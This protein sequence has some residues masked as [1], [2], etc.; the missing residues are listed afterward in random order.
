MD[1]H[2]LVVKQEPISP[3][4]GSYINLKVA[5]NL[6]ELDPFFRVKRDDPLQQ[7]FIK[8]SHRANVD[9][10]TIR[11]LYDG[12]R[13]DRNRTPNQMGMEDGDCIDAMTE[14]IGGHTMI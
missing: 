7:L 5:S 6:N 4:K 11:F 9:Y 3:T 14:Q 10:H 8:W 2:A 12:K 1:P 13:V